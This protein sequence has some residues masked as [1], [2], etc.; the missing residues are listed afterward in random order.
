MLR[1]DATGTL[2][3]YPPEND[4]PSSADVTLFYP[5]GSE[6]KASASATID[7]ASTTLASNASKGARSVSLTSATGTS[8]SRRYLLQESGY[9]SIC[10]VRRISGTTAYLVGQ[11]PRA[12]TTSATWKG[13]RL[14]L[15]VD[16]AYT[17]ERDDNYRAQWVYTIGSDTYTRESIYSVV[18]AGY[19]FNTTWGD[20][21]AIHPR[22]TD[23]LE[24]H[25][26][27]GY[28]IMR[29][30]WNQRIIPALRARELRIER[31]RDYDALIP[32]HVAW[33]NEIMMLEN[34]QHDIDKREAFELAT[35]NREAIQQAIMSDLN[36]YDS[37]DDLSAES[38]EEHKAKTHLTV[39]R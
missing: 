8:A 23:L 32:L 29:T 34:A 15:S 39:T 5:D 26:Q 38:G 20:V 11:L 28:E 27:D 21:L 36:W 12:Y 19:Y 9:D 16:S 1:E 31:I 35:M 7:S 33:I 25:D 18:S 30:A 17:A 10:E 13:W 24:D 22:L 4:V 37:D 3:F 2:E 14:S 6:L